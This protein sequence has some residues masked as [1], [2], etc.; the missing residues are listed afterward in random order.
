MDEQKI[1]EAVRKEALRYWQGA[2][3]PI[4]IEDIWI[5]QRDADG[6]QVKVSWTSESCADQLRDDM[7]YTV[8]V[9]G[10][11]IVEEFGPEW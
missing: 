11:E 7:I 3:E 8:T 5:E 10:G 6:V 4:E 1:I 9:E 2:D